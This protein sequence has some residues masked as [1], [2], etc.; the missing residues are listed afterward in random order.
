MQLHNHNSKFNM[1]NKLTGNP[2]KYSQLHVIAIVITKQGPFQSVY[3]EGRVWVKE[4]LQIKVNVIVTG[5]V[6][7]MVVE[8]EVWFCNVTGGGG[9]GVKD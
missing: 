2:F 4:L 8:A 1:Y 7:G 9:E 6:G 3:A 5:W